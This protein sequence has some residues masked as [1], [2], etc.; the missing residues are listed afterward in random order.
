MIYILD[1]VKNPIYKPTSV[2]IV[3]LVMGTC[4]LLTKLQHGCPLQL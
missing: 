4:N 2:P 1:Q 3:L